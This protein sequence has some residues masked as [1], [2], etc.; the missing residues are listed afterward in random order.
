MKKK[1]KKLKIILILSVI[2]I[3]ISHGVWVW[4]TFRYSQ[5][6][7]DASFV[8]K[9]E[10]LVNGETY[11]FE[12]EEDLNFIKSFIE[13]TSYFDVTWGKCAQVYVYESL[14]LIGDNRSLELRPTGDDC[15]FYGAPSL[16]SNQTCYNLSGRGNLRSLAEFFEN[17]TEQE[18][19]Y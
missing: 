1:S 16:I 10:L 13:G 2:A 6:K 19:I 15:G 14:I 3:L 4:K 17:K 18:I 8:K 7:F 5:R 9:I 12:D 11:T